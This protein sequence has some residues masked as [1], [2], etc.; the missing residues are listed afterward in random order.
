MT[1]CCSIVFIHKSRERRVVHEINYKREEFREYHHLF[2]DPKRDKARFFEYTRMTQE[3]FNYT[4]NYIFHTDCLACTFT[5]RGSTSIL[6]SSIH[7]CRLSRQVW[8]SKQ[9]SGLKQI[10]GADTLEPAFSVYAYTCLY[11]LILGMGRRQLPVWANLL[12][13]CTHPKIRFYLP[14]CL[15]SYVLI[16]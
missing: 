13:L 12:S 11:G 10:A 2:S 9:E 4:L 15:L 5:I 14:L 7:L 1:S 8:K 3:T 6:C 16:G